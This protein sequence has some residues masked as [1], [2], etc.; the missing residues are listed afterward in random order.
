MAT[1]NHRIDELLERLK[2]L[3]PEERDRISEILCYEDPAISSGTGD[4]SHSAEQLLRLRGIIS[5]GGDAV[6]D[7]E[8]LYE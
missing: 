1:G 4:R 8:R 3:S 6:K 7:T 5:I 2:H